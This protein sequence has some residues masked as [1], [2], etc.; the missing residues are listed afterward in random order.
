MIEIVISLFLFSSPAFSE[1][2]GV[3][4]THELSSNAVEVVTIV[5]YEKGKLVYRSQHTTVELT[6]FYFANSDADKTWGPK[7]AD[8]QKAEMLTGMW[9]PVGSE[10]VIVLDS[11]NV[12]SLLATK[13]GNDYRFWSPL[14]TGSTA[15]F[16]CGPPASVIK[17]VFDQKNTS[18]DGCNYPASAMKELIESK[19]QVGT[20]AP[21][22][23]YD[24][25][26]DSDCTLV[27]GA[28]GC[29]CPVAIN[30]KFKADLSSGP[31]VCD[32]SC[33]FKSESKKTKALCSKGKCQATKLK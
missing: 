26:K 6:A 27:P 13:R 16:E 3:N 2:L 30:G 17:T 19:V 10:V 12:V 31:V 11:K 24:C 4:L 15:F 25:K 1:S 18:W 7:I 21:P 29:G 22:L 33:D 28:N 23:V 14:M 32:K 9:P 20:K 8:P 5:R